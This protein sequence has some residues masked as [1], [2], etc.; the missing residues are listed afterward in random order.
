M[1][2]TV[3]AATGGLNV[4]GGPV[5]R[6]PA[7][8]W[9]L[10]GGG[11]GGVADAPGRRG[12]TAIRAR[13]AEKRL[14]GL[15]SVAVAAERL[16]IMAETVGHQTVA[17]NLKLK[18]ALHVSAFFF[19]SFFSHPVSFC[20][21][22]LRSSLLYSSSPVLCRPIHTYLPGRSRS[23]PYPPFCPVKLT[24]HPFSHRHHIFV[25]S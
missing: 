21:P 8:E 24:F 17:G 4:D 6:T 7:A 10:G 3:V 20:P 9:C 22:P 11:G 15:L 5:V 25:P 2:C 18:L 23:D 16:R 12:T 14:D 1:I 13:A 19:S